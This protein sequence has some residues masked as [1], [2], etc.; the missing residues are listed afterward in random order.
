MLA[1]ASGL[2]PCCP[3]SLP[4]LLPPTANPLLCSGPWYTQPLPCPPTRRDELMEDGFSQIGRMDPDRVKGRLRIQYV[5]E[6][7]LP[8][9]GIDGGGLFKDFME[10]LLRQGFSPQ[11]GRWVQGNGAETA[12]H[13]MAWHSCHNAT[14]VHSAVMEEDRVVSSAPAWAIM[15]TY[16]CSSR[17]SLVACVIVV[18][19]FNGKTCLCVGPVA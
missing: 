17:P 8:E 9:A 18:G 12:E 3:F 10:E 11:V 7:G 16:A 1:G 15:F 5:N 14:T 13:G 4:A 2:L 19:F 6:A